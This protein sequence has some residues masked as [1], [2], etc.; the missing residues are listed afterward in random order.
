MANNNST[1]NAAKEAQYDEFY[2]RYEDIELEVMSYVKHNPDVFKGKTVLLPCDDPDWSNFLKFFDNRF[3]T[4]G[5]KKLIST[6]YDKTGGQ[7]KLY[8]KEWA[9]GKMTKLMVTSLQGDGD[10][11]SPEVAQLHAEADVIITNPPFSLFREFLAWIGDKQFLILGSM[12]NSVYKDVF[13]LIRDGKVWVG[14]T[15]FNAGMYFRVPED[16]TYRPTYKFA[17][18]MD[19]EK[20][21]RVPGLCWFTNLDHGKRHEP[22]PMLTMAENKSFNP[23]LEYLKYD[24]YDAIEVPEVN[25]IPS[26]YIGVMGV[27]VTFLDKFNPDQFEIVGSNRGVNQDPDGVYGRGTKLNGKEISKRLFI[28]PK[29]LA[30]GRTPATDGT[31]EGTAA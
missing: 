8:T 5:L 13:P 19:G 28:Q 21:A 27:P 1:M 16:F 4:L 17:K 14:V 6:S 25:L 10:F 24:N 29:N 31:T 26:D 3:A 15:G 22:L 20:V 11:R 2:T 7:G 18:E 9:G 30:A 12:G 23:G